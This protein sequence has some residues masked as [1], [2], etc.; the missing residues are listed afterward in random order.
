MY[1]EQ[2]YKENPSSNKTK[3]CHLKKLTTILYI[4]N[5]SQL[6]LLLVTTEFQL[7]S[8]KKKTIQMQQVVLCHPYLV[9]LQIK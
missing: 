7:S 8:T 6:S 9:G 1:R 3:H 2:R 4:F 5:T